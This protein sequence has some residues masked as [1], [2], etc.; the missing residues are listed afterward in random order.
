MIKFSLSLVLLLAALLI[1][2]VASCS[3]TQYKSNG[4]RIYYTATSSSGKPIYSQGFTM[5]HGNIAC[6]NCHGADGHGGNVHIMMTSFEAPNI[7]WA[8]LT[9]QHE[10]HAPYTEATVKDA[11]TKGLEPN[12]KELEIYMPRWQMANEDLDDLLSFLKTLK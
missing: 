4:E 5:M 11:I 6:V 9:G 1:A 3:S 7:T 8:V 2:L 10:D 12:G